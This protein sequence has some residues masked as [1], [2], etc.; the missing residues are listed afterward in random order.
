MNRIPRTRATGI[1]LAFLLAATAAM[2]FAGTTLSDR[3]YLKGKDEPTVRT[4]TEDDINGVKLGQISFRIDAVDRIEY[5]DAPAAYRS[6]V[7]HQKQGRYEEAIQLYQNALRS[8]TARK[9]WIGQYCLYAIAQ[10]Y[11][12]MGELDKAAAAFKE[13]VAKEPQTR[14][15]PNAML[16]AGRILFEKQD[17]T[18]AVAAFDKLAGK[19]WEEWKYLASLWKAKAH[20]AGKKYS[21]A[22]A[23]AKAIISGSAASKYPNIVIQARSIEARVNVG[24]GK[25]EEAVKLLK[26]LI[27]D[28]APA[29]AKERE[30]GTETDMQRIEAQCKNALGQCYLKKALK[31]K[32]DDDYRA[33]RLAFLWTVVLYSN[34]HEERAEA[35]YYGAKTFAKLGDAE[36]QKELETELKELYPDA[37]FE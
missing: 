14:F 23:V 1:A 6:A 2:S 33:A 19:G 22:L 25:F 18:G 16:A 24:Q 26:D 12:E 35:L 7:L 28:I 31:T 15:L 30:A 8:T 34:F 11:L 37:K 36:R 21:E 3:V 13:L 9:F 5:A 20:L 17:Y 32:S 10:C 4:V 29:V 27:D